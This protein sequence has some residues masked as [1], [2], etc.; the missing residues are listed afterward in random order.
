MTVLFCSLAVI[1]LSHLAGK[2]LHYSYLSYGADF[3]KRALVFVLPLLITLSP[4]SFSSPSLGSTNDQANKQAKTLLTI[5]GSNTIGADLAPALVQGY[6]KHIGGR[7]VE[8]AVT[9]E[10][11][12]A[13]YAALPADRKSIKKQTVRVDIAAHGSST[14][15]TALQTQSTDIAAASR[16]AKKKEIDSL[17]ELTQLTSAASEHILAIDGLA[18]IINPSNPINELSVQQVA[19]IFAGEISDWSQV[20][21]RSGQINLYARDDKSGTWDSFKRMVLEKRKLYSQAAR[22]ESNQTLSWHI[23]N[24]PQGIGFVGL[25][26]VNKSKLIAISDGAAKALKPTQLTIATEDYA[27]S[28]RLHL[29]T[30]DEPNNPHVMPFI[31]FALSKEGQKIV[32]DTG[33]IAQNIHA[34]QPEGYSEL[35]PNFKQLTHQG[36][37]LTVNFRFKEGSAQL[38]NRALRDIERLA[39]FMQKQP[40]KS[41]VLIGFGDQK[42]T[43]ERS[44]LLSK[45][46]SMA[47]RRELVKQGIYPRYSYGY[48]EQL[49]V[50]SNQSQLGR[51]KNRRVEAWL[52]DRQ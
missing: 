3:M 7:A 9:G 18:I 26:A 15:F 13:I 48:G 42:K 33:F 32:A 50:A 38:D 2:L 20:G 21:G 23:S 34:V 12:Q 11:E 49:P 28:R 5:T 30:T 40:T 47:V 1:K 41:L 4:T 17:S 37:R 36:E 19:A 51:I 35:P 27:L 14:G 6:L 24:D 16:R 45:L 8:T 22:F 31:Q 43:K 46:R 10:N 44:V 29:Y 52:I 39:A 25:P